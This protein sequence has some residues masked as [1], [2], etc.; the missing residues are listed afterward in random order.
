[1]IEKISEVLINKDVEAVIISN[2]SNATREKLTNIQKHQRGGLSGKPM[3]DKSNLLINKF[4]KHF[5]QMIKNEWPEYPH[6]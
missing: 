5:F 1:M 6:I 3:E 2:T 4:Y